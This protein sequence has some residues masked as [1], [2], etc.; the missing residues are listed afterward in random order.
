MRLRW[1]GQSAFH[2]T[3]SDR[4]ILIDPFISG[5]PTAPKDALDGVGTIDAILLTH[6]HDD[7]LGDTVD[8]A[9]RY[10]S[11]LVAQF[12]ICMWANAQGVEKLQPMN[13]GGKIDLDGITIAMVQAFHSSAIVRDGVPITMG[14]PAGLIVTADGTTI[15][16]AGDTGIFSDMALIQ[17]IYQPTVGLIP[18]GDRF[19]MGP[20]LAAM[21]CN[22]FLDLKTIVPIH[23]GTFDLL[24]GDPQDFAKRVTRGEVK[25][26]Q[27][28]E[29]IDV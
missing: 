24:T 21:A 25:V 23:W 3:T 29:S 5:S 10:G 20:E 6:G 13:T 14:D 27:P 22:E 19:T 4:S 26:L 11:T 9:K 18:V 16:H 12:E 8:I 2:L 28:G 15:Y 7:H 1:L 17:R